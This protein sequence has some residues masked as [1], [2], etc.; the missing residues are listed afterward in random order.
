MTRMLK[1]EDVAKV[2][3]VCESKAYQLI[4]LMNQE[5]EEKGFLTVRGRI[6]EDYFNER[7]F[8]GRRDEQADI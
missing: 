2:L 5:L 1:A 8:G 7:F 3:Q 4:R 6:S